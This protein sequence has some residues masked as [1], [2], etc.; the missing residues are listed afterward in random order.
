MSELDIVKTEHVDFNVELRLESGRLLGPLT[1]AYE[2]Y[3][4]LNGDKSNAILVAHAWTG[5]AHAAGRHNSEDR[6]PGWWDDMIGPG[7][8]LDTDRYF[9]ICSTLSAPASA[10]RD[11]PA[12]TP[13]PASPTTCSFR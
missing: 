2:T 1:I 8:V 12:K 6:K 13:E 5:D 10:Q 9:V 4:E 3:G 7:K 11:R